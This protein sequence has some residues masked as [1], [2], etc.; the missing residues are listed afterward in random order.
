MSRFLTVVSLL[1]SLLP[2]GCGQAPPVTGAKESFIVVADI[3]PE[4][5]NDIGQQILAAIAHGTPG[6]VIHV[7][8]ATRHKPVASLVVPDV[9]PAA[10]LRRSSVR[11]PLATIAAF[12]NQDGGGSD[13]LQIPEVSSAVNSLRRTALPC[14]IV[15]AGTPVYDDPRHAG[16]SFKHGA[17]ASD[18][19]LSSDA[20]P[21]SKGVADFPPGSRVSWLTPAAD[22]GV[23]APHRAAVTRFWRLFFAAHDAELVRLTSDPAAGFAAESASQFAE[24]A[25][26]RNEPARMIAAAMRT[27]GDGRTNGERTIR[28]KPVKSTAAAPQQPS[29]QVSFS[30]PEANEQAIVAPPAVPP[31]I[32]ALPGSLERVA[33]LL[34]LSKSMTAGQ[35][36]QQN[37]QQQFAAVKAD[38]QDKLRALPCDE[39][40]VLG[41]G[42]QGDDVNAPRIEAYPSYWFS[43]GWT[44]ATPENRESACQA[45][46]SWEA[47]GGTPTMP[48]M[49]EALKLDGLTTVLLYTDGLPNVGGTQAE[50]LTL[51][52]EKDVV[53]NTIGVGSFSAAKPEDFD[54]AGGEFLQRLSE[55]TGGRFFSFGAGGE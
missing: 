42:G 35:D 2:A 24:A 55:M 21:L 15:L 4:L 51:L 33:I 23:D 30:S 29:D 25:T 44:E 37:L 3:G 1:A 10:R 16:W 6:D 48:A 40:F 7:I 53:V 20:S 9:P 17:V 41:F 13:Q 5:R 49:M 19:A 32:D 28:F 27:P 34:D 8:S 18:G 12:L 47:G 52:D 22:F 43:P 39:F 36:Q 38:V 50:L 26:P 31:T 54:M 45:V 11:R 46:V 14:S